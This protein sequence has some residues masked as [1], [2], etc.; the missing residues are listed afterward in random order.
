M[1][2]ITKTYLPAALALGLGAGLGLSDGTG[3][4]AGLL[5]AGV[6][7]VTGFGSLFWGLK[8]GR[9][10]AEQLAADRDRLEALLA[11]APFP[12]CAWHADGSSSLSEECRS[13]LGVATADELMTLVDGG[14]TVAAAVERLRRSGEPFRLET[15]A[16]DGRRFVLTGRRGAADGHA[17]CSVVWIEDISDRVHA[18]DELRAARQNADS[19]LAE[20][21]AAADALPVPLWVRGADLSL[22]WCNSA[23]ARAVDS[24]PATAIAEQR[25]LAGGTGGDGRALAGR[26]RSAGFAQSERMP[27]VIGTERR[28]LEVT[29]APL[30]SPRGSGTLVVGYA[31]DLTEMEGLQGELKRHLAAHAEVLER[32]GTAIAIFGPDTRLRFFNQA[33]ARLWDLD[34]AWLRTEP[35][36]AELLEELRARRR[37]PEYADYQTFKR[38]RLT[39]YTHLMEP[40]E[41]LMHLPDGTTLRH[42]AAPHPLGG[43]IT[44]LE[45]VTNTLALESSYNTLIAVQQETL[46]NLAE[47]I[48]VFGGDGRLKL[49]NPAFARV[50][51]LGDEDLQGEPHIAEVIELMRPLLENGGDWDTLKEEMI[52][53]TLERTV[54]SG[55]LERGDGSVVEFSTLPLP[56]GAVLNSYLDVTD[57][58]RLEHALRASNAALEAADQLK[59]EFIANVSHHLRTPLNGIIGF[60]EVLANEY[61]GTLNARQMEYVKGVLNAGERLLELIDDV[62]D[63]TSLGAGV[64]TLERGTVDVSDLLGSVAGLTREW[65]R[66]EGL[67]LEIAAPAGLGAIEGDGKRLKQALFTL[68]VGAIRNPP[69]SGRIQLGGSRSEDELVLTVDGA[70]TTADRPGTH[71]SAALG[72]SLAR[73][74]IELH[75]GRLEAEDGLVRCVLP[76]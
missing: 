19:A 9:R 58:A 55:R 72:L 23:Y 35:T 49:S 28:L 21:R 64:A 68:V 37:L 27:V 56:D 48:A 24:D 4:P 51:D 13:A 31:L 62:V 63:L 3:S 57:S 5:L 43:L 61:F 2:S 39:R 44:I 65:A 52:G 50:W 22:V 25:E 42:L 32:L 75:G 69:R 14:E 34:E 15:T 16:R 1:D 71:E 60:A 70:A 59:S 12:W 33:Y 11:A 26:A 45:D 46:D 41:E 76:V 18:D 73:N 36:N 47:G 29:E 67:K 54:R 10:R 30:P 53:A 17:A 6:L 40:M 66:R 20:L 7:S 8:T 38:E 74:V